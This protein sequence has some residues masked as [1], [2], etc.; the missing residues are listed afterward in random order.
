MDGFLATIAMPENLFRALCCAWPIQLLYSWLIQRAMPPKSKV[1]YWAAIAAVSLPLALLK[2]VLPPLVTGVIGIALSVLLPVLLLSG[3]VVRRVVVCAIGMVLMAASELVSAVVWLQLTG[4]EVMDAS[5]ALAHSEAFLLCAAIGYG[6]V[7][8]PGL[9]AVA[10]LCRRFFPDDTAPATV[11]RSGPSWL[12][13]IA[14]LPILQVPFVFILLTVSFNLTRG[15]ASYVGVALALLAFA[16][17]VDAFLFVQIS[18]SAESRRAELEAALLEERLSGYLGESTAVQALLDDTAR[19]RH[20]VRNHQS[21]VGTLCER[22]EYAAAR[23]YLEEVVE[24][25]RS[26]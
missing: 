21:V 15:E 6:S 12:G 17:A 14:L 3:P 22:G 2:I 24:P 19:L 11:G 18:R 23:D 1:R 10:A 26:S 9:L 25:L 20:D 16:F 4:L 13:R 5:L 8:V 7:M